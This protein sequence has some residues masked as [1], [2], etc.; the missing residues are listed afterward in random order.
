MAL[1]CSYRFNQVKKKLRV[2]L[3]DLLYLDALSRYRRIEANQVAILF[4]LAPT[5]KG[6]HKLLDSATTSYLV[7][8]STAKKHF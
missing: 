7:K 8:C 2:N 4:E 1:H 5:S 3:T 6:N